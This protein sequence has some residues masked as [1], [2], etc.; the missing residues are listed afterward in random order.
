[1]SHV[2]SHSPGVSVC[3]VVTGRTLARDDA[4]YHKVY[5]RAKVGAELN[6]THCLPRAIR[7]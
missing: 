3:A 1:M 2:P 4:Q 7:V 6:F 5:V